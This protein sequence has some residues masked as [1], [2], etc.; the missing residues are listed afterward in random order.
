MAS[1]LQTLTPGTLTVG[2]DNPAF[3]PYYEPNDNGAKTKPWELGDPTN[4]KGLE[5]ATAFAVAA[6]L[7]Y[8]KDQVTWKAVPFNNAIAPGSKPFDMYLTQVS[9]SAKRA[10]VVDLSDGYFDLNQAVVALKSNSITQVTD[11]AGLK[12]FTLGTQSGTT[13]FDYITN[14]IQPTKPPRAYDSLNA[15]IRALNAK[16]IDGIVADLPTTFYMRDAQLKDAQ[17]VGS[18][19][20]AGGTVEHF[21][22]LLAK[23]SA[24]TPCVNEALAAMKSDGTLAGIVQQWITSQGAPELK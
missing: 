24:L 11:V 8:T 15:A 7:G 4:G 10:N 2:A 6:K 14:T 5:S 17:I 16:Q 13:S 19:P 18:L 22:I 21:S 20:Q 9:Y 1:S 23:G 3:P 12:S